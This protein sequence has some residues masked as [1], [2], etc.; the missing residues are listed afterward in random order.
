MLT[1]RFPTL[2]V[3]GFDSP[4]FGFDAD[5]VALDMVCRRA[6]EAKPDV[7]FV[8]L[9]FPKQERLIVRLREALPSAWFMGCGAAIGF[10]AGV[11][12]RA[13]DWMQRAGLEWAH[14]LINEPGR[15]VR[16]YLLH[17]MPFAVRLLTMS[18][19]GRTGPLE[20]N[21]K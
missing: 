16:R 15:L 6:A 13:P 9:G 2:A 4:P 21:Q 20:V 10:V 14:R 11:R 19:L 5:P 1:D 8:G 7:V 18:A 3:S 12:R 17:D